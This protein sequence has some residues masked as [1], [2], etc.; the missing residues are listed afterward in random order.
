[1]WNSSKAG[2]LVF[3]KSF[4]PIQETRFWEESR[5][6][7]KLEY[8]G[9]TFF[10]THMK[11]ISYELKNFSRLKQRF[12][13]SGN[14]TNS[15]LLLL[16]SGVIVSSE[17]I[18]FFAYDY[19]MCNLL[20]LILVDEFDVNIVWHLNLIVLRF[21]HWKFRFH[22]EASLISS[23]PFLLKVFFFYWSR[24]PHRRAKLMVK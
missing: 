17:V 20:L 3:E 14:V 8:N 19:E 13:F 24:G 5:G 6:N 16:L 4:S 23:K 21:L 10:S 12:Y 22:T 2:A 15:L 1:M 9:G 11:L 7:Y 18:S